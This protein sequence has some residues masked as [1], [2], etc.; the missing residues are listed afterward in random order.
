M[1]YA[2]KPPL[3]LRLGILA[4]VLAVLLGLHQCYQKLQRSQTAVTSV[5]PSTTW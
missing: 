2:S 3:R 1:T 5:P 4:A